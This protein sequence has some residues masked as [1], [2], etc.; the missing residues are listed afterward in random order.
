MS[1][2]GTATVA[3]VAGIASAAVGVAVCTGVAVLGWWAGST[4]T[5]LDAV[6]AGAD[7][8]LLAHGSALRTSDMT[9]TAVPLGLTVLSGLLL[10][11]AG[12]AVAAHGRRTTSAPATRFLTTA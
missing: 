1:D 11:R 7:A 4:G 9:V 3:A 2:L 5:A 8:W 12:G 6:R 10:W